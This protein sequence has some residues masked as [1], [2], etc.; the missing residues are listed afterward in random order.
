MKPLLIRAAAAM[1]A[2]AVYLWLAILGGGG[3]SAFFSNPARTALAIV[4][5]ALGVA[6]I[7]V[8]GSLSPG[9][10]EDRSNR[11]VIFAFLIIGLVAA[12]LPAWSD[13]QGFWRL[14][15]EAVRWLGV[16]LVAGGGALRLW[17]VAVL[18]HRFSGLVAIQ[19]GHRL[20]TSGLYSRIRHPSYL[21]L[22][23]TAL[24]W[25]LAFNTG[26]GVLLALLNIPPLV[27]RM[28][29]EER[30]LSSEFGAEYDAYRARTARLIPGL[31]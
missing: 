23:I 11:W 13:R 22:F 29:S 10:R 14:D 26:V 24:G 20:V 31:Y 17:P 18:G 15:G 19:P 8:G 7:F 3:F 2:I 16:T 5:T 27:A 6:S 21:G 4:T 25:G 9:L 28:N 30:L 1:G 12:Y